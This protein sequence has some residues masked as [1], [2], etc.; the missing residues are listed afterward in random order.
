MI[1]IIITAIIIMFNN[2]N[3]WGDG[4]VEWVGGVI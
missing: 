3:K 2:K 1:I 4:V